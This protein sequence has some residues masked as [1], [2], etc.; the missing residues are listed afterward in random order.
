MFGIEHLVHPLKRTARNARPRLGM[1]FDLR[2]FV[3]QSDPRFSE[4][5]KIIFAAQEGELRGDC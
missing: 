3:A 5:A 1:Q 4:T 2:R